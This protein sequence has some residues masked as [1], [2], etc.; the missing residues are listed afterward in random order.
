LSRFL[1]DVAGI[2][3]I[4]IHNRG[5]SLAAHLAGEQELRSVGGDRGQEVT[6]TSRAR[7]VGDLDW[8][9]AANGHRPDEP[10]MT[11]PSLHTYPVMDLTS[12]RR[13]ALELLA[14][15]DNI[16]LAGST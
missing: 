14:H 15:H 13:R 1:D 11:R 5:A 4:E 10:A 7:R 2:L 12:D 9:A 16:L 3:A 8:L 6:I